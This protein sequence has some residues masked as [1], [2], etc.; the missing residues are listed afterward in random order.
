MASLIEPGVGRAGVGVGVSLFGEFLLMCVV[1]QHCDG[2][3][4]KSSDLR[5]ISVR[6][7]LCCRFQ[8]VRLI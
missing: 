7:L 6:Y 2:A 5:V 1:C 4:G 8:W 3:S